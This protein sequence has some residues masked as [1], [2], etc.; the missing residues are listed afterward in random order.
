MQAD[1][2]SYWQKHTVL[3]QKA[4]NSSN[5]NQTHTDISYENYSILEHAWWATTV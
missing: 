4:A 1:S 5:G 2:Y 3:N